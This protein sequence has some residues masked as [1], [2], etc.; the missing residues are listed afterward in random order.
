M[1]NLFADVER[2]TELYVRAGETD[3]LQEKLIKATIMQNWPDKIVTNLSFQLKTAKTIGEMQSLVNINLHDHKIGLPKGQTG[4]M[5]CPAEDEEEQTR[6][7]A[8]VVASASKQS[9][10]TTRSDK[11]K[12]LEEQ[13]V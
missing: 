2:I 5:L 12:G 9:E 8:S 4:P 10:D 13:K 11:I 3:T 7:Y 1:D 6:T